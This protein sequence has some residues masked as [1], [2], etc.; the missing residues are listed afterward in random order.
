MKQLNLI[1]DIDQT[2][3]QT[4]WTQQVPKDILDQ[5]KTKLKYVD[6]NVYGVEMTVF[7]RPGLQQFLDFAFANFNV[8]ILTHSLMPYAEQIVRA[9]VLNKP[10][11][12]LTFFLDR[13]Y[14]DEQ[15]ASSYGGL[16]NLD[17]LLKVNPRPNGW[18]KCNTF[19]LD[20]NFEVCKTN[21]GNCLTLPKFRLA[22]V[23]GPM[24][25]LSTFRM[26]TFHPRGVDDTVLYDT[27][28]VLEGLLRQYRSL[29]ERV[30]MKRLCTR[31]DVP[32]LKLFNLRR[33]LPR[34]LIERWNYQVFENAK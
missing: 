22:T 17:Y 31:P 11:R 19:I 15:Q 5:Y 8:A 4:L 14:I 16:K 12:H 3:V 27:M 29:A 21:V 7:E 33:N 26:Y 9:L 30:G 24:N 25:V 23:N 1:L 28:K 32:L 10:G 2:L 13:T 34:D 6:I 18:S 20:D